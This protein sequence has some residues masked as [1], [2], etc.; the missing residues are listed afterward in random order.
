MV[1]ADKQLKTREDGLKAAEK[2]LVDLRALAASFDVRLNKGIQEAVDRKNKEL[3]TAHAQQIKLFT[4]EAKAR[5][6]LLKQKVESLEAVIKS[7]Q[8]EMGRMSKQVDVLSDQ[9][10]KIAQSAVSRISLGTEIKPQS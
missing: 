6:D 2:E 8:A 4:Q 10:T 5:E 1:T 7:Q 3:E 9:L